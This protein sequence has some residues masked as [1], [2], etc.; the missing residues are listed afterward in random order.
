MIDKLK[1]FKHIRIDKLCKYPW[2]TDIYCSRK[3]TENGYCDSCN[4]MMS[5]MRDLV[6][7]D[8]KIFKKIVW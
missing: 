8:V 5:R 4:E 2:L 7:D 1:K 3:A 6:P